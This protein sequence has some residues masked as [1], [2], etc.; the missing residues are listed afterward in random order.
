MICIIV[1]LV[2]PR[3]FALVLEPGGSLVPGKGGVLN[4][5]FGMGVRFAGP[6]IG[7]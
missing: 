2:S 4:Y 6:E 7:A 3:G 1:G 5:Y